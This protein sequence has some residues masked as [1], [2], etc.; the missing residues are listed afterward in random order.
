MFSQ[1]TV[2]SNDVTTLDAH[3]RRLG[4]KLLAAFHNKSDPNAL[5]VLVK[6]GAPVNYRLSYGLEIKCESTFV[7]ALYLLL[8]GDKNKALENA[9]L[10]KRGNPEEGKQLYHYTS[11]AIAFRCILF[12]GN[13]NTTMIPVAKE[14]KKY[15]YQHAI[16]SRF[17]PE[18]GNPKNG[19]LIIAAGL[20]DPELVENLIKAGNLSDEPMEQN[21]AHVNFEGYFDGYAAEW[22]TILMDLDT[23]SLLLKHGS[24]TVKLGMTQSSLLHWIAVVARLDESEIY[25][26]KALAM[27]QYLLD[28]GCRDHENI[29]GKTAYDYAEGAIKEVLSSYHKKWAIQESLSRQYEISL[30]KNNNPR[31]LVYEI[32]VFYLVARAIHLAI[33]CQLPKHVGNGIAFET[34]KEILIEYDENALWQLL[35]ILSVRKL[36]SLDHKKQMIYP[37][38]LS[39]CLNEHRQ[40]LHVSAQTWMN[41]YDPLSDETSMAYLR[42]RLHS[43]VEFRVTHFCITLVSNNP[44]TL[45]Q[46]MAWSHIVSRLIRQCA[47]CSLFDTINEESQ[48]NVNEAYLIERLIKK[49]PSYHPDSLRLMFELLSRYGFLQNHA[50][51]IQLTELGKILTSTHPASLKSAMLMIDKKWWG[52]ASCLEKSFLKE[53]KSAFEHF[54]NENFYSA[55]E[56]KSIFGEGMAAISL[57]EDFEVAEALSRLKVIRDAEVIIDVGGGHAHLLYELNQRLPNKK[58]ILFEKDGQDAKQLGIQI[59]E[60]YSIKPEIILGDFMRSQSG[61]PKYK[62]A[63]Y[64]IKCCLHNLSDEDTRTVLKNI[65]LAAGD[66]NPIFVIERMIPPQCESRPHMNRQSNLLMRLLFKANPHSYTFYQNKLSEVNLFPME[67]IVAGNYLLISALSQL[68]YQKSFKTM[69]DEGTSS[70]FEHTSSTRKQTESDDKNQ[71]CSIVELFGCETNGKG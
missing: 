21:G 57:L 52:A 55:Y 34:L 25:Q 6:E 64:L 14:F 59:Q 40:Q 15:L 70:F 54:N 7:A 4:E 43:N 62:N 32:S 65:Q 18:P 50:G 22:S 61:I 35:E 20:R 19:S 44:L 67:P 11:T 28:Q 2:E 27:T 49:Y 17:E 3:N 9:T 13:A 46:E 39:H 10:A 51:Q 69:T 23:L 41:H 66:E 16:K 29:F 37:T 63:I 26:T 45:L 1:T 31:E 38:E 53:G 8:E 30:Q 24:K 48:E 56:G 36:F 47:E 58:M 12:D 68:S 42:G 5:A 71:N 60:K 33:A